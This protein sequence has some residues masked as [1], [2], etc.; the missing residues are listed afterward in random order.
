MKLLGSSSFGYHIMDRSRHTVIKYLSDEQTHATN[1]SKLF[2]RARS[3]EHFIVWSWFHRSTDWTQRAN[4]Y[5]VIHSSIRK[6]ANVGAV[7][8]LLHQ[9]LW[10]KK[11]GRVGNGHRFAVSCSGRERT[12]RLYQTWNES[13][14]AEVA[15]KWMCR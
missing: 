4:H 3:C 1:I 2:K 8:Q 9:I 5:R 14:M 15:I 12:E 13:G 11:V 10:F 6:T 7:L